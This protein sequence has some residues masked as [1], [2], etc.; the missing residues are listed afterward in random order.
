M[1]AKYTLRFNASRPVGTVD[2]VVAS[3]VTSRTSGVIDE[4][5]I[6]QSES[7]TLVS[8]TVAQIMVTFLAANDN[9]A[10]AISYDAI[11]GGTQ[12]HGVAVDT[13]TLNG[14]SGRITL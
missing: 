1:S 12:G 11:T 2:G 7:Y 14:G 5:C 13:I 10:K 4:H 6:V 8:E 9:E 3:A